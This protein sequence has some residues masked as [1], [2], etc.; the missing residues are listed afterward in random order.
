MQTLDVRA[1][2]DA[3]AFVGLVSIVDNSPAFDREVDRVGNETL[4]VSIVMQARCKIP[5]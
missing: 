4:M 5:I 1:D 2:T 3:N